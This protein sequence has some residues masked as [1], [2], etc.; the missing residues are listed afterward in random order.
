MTEKTGTTSAQMFDLSGEIALVTGSAR[1]I[2]REIAEGFLQAGAQVI[3]TSRDAHRAQA[4]AAEL[5]KLHDGITHA[6]VLDVRSPQSVDELFAWVA[7]DLGRLD[8]LVNN[9]GGHR[10][11]KHHHLWDRSLDDWTWFI[12]TNLT[13]TFLCTQGAVRL[14]MQA[15][16]GVIINIAS[17][18]GLVGRD[19]RLY[20]DQDMI[21][22][23]GD[24]AACKAGVLGLT[25][26]NA[27]EMAPY[28]IRINA[29]S[30]GGIERGQPKGF[31]EGYA[32][33]TP[34]GRMGRADKELKG[35]A[36]LLA[37]EAGAYITGQN[38]IVDGGFTIFK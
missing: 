8:I 7:R 26:D 28:G 12:E 17:I 27:A 15:R 16:K 9:A 19:R 20:E 18:A 38:I 31:I 14:M 29:I 11:A 13:G 37:S 6:H 34:L 35:A 22:N 23:T 32:Y 4:T 25:R 21:P 1:G 30:P 36:L 33:R 5:A 24:Y 2:G 3:V 10:N